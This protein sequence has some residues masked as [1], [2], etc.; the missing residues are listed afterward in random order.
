[1][2]KQNR[3]CSLGA[4]VL[5][6][7]VVGIANIIPGVSGGTMALVL[8]IY[9]RLIN[10]IHSISLKTVVIIFKVLSFKKAAIDDFVE[11]MK[12]IDLVFLVTLF[13]GAAL[14][15]FFLA[16][17][18]EYLLVDMHDPTYGFFFGLVAASVVVPFKE[19]KKWSFSVVLAAFIAAMAVAATEFAD[20]D[21]GRIAKAQQKYELKLEKDAVQ[22]SSF[23]PVTALVL[24]G[25]GATAISAMIL[26]GISG[27]FLLILM[28]QYFVILKAVND[29]NI[30][31]LMVFCLGIIAGLAVFTRFLR[32]LME[33]WFNQTMGFLGG[34]VVGSLVIIWPFRKFELV[35]SD[36]VDGYPEKVFLS[37]VFPEMNGNFLVSVI[38]CAIGIALVVIM[39]QV[40]KNLN[41][42]A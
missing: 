6:G 39:M 4:N 14:A 33:K 18:M 12:R 31:Y 13:S 19:V 11:E 40:E 5:R 10:A 32:F 38:A 3:F 41:K 35:G 27:S 1:M 8:G 26:P 17:V 25:S 28:G 42:K 20:T 23:E 15:V 29:F 30:P 7:M 9:E 16:S 34:L 37:I 22:D 24:F 36:L 21:Q 2:E